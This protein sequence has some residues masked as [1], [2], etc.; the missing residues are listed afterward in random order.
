MAFI[1]GAVS[2]NYFKVKDVQQFSR[3][4]QFE[5]EWADCGL[6]I[7][8]E[9][10]VFY[11]GWGENTYLQPMRVPHRE[12]EDDEDVE[13][14]EEPEP[15]DI[16]EFTAQFREH[17]AEPQEVAFRELTSGHQWRRT[18]IDTRHTCHGPCAFPAVRFIG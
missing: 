17:L 2:S 18:R 15:C 5:I 11:R 12:E 1:T 16:P 8:H 3:W 7:E 9:G 6:V 13:E 4:M 10:R 14:W